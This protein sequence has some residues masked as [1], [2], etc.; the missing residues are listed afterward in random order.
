MSMQSLLHKMSY[1]NM[2]FG[3]LMRNILYTSE[4]SD[5]HA[6]RNHKK[7]QKK[8]TQR[9]AANDKLKACV[10]PDT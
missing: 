2:N 8:R 1:N 9:S 4:Y 6:V 10:Y 5:K 7:H 3:T